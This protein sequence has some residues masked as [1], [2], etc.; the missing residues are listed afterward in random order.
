MDGCLKKR[1]MMKVVEQKNYWMLV[2]VHQEA[3]KTK[4]ESRLRHKIIKNLN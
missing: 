4:N 2:V 3:E 1:M